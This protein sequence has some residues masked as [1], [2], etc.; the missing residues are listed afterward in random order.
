MDGLTPS[1]V[2]CFWWAGRGGGG[3]GGEMDVTLH[4]DEKQAM[5]QT[6]TRCK[7]LT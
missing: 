7:F 4:S 5:K 1:C 6:F 2:I 3:C